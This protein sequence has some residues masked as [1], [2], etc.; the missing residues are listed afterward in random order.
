[1]DPAVLTEVTSQTIRII[2]TSD[3]NMTIIV[4]IIKIILHLGDFNSFVPN[5]PFLCLLKTPCRFLMFSLGRE[6]V[7]WERMG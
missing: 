7:H 3:N 5:A 4:I 2:W 1:M 6:R